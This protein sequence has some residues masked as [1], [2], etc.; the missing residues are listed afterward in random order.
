MVASLDDLVRFHL[1]FSVYGLGRFPVTLYKE[2][3]A[4]LLENAAGIRAFLEEHSVFWQSSTLG[5]PLA[6]AFTFSRST[7]RDGSSRSL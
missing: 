3:W 2:Q 5:V 6:L 7:T 4:R 1:P